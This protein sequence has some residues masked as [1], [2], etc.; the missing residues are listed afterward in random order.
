MAPYSLKFLRNILFFVGGKKVERLDDSLD[1][2][3]S[4]QEYVSDQLH[5][6]KITTFKRRHI[7]SQCFSLYVYIKMYY[8]TVRVR[9]HVV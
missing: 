7:L 1:M 2:N 3:E 6:N 8:G 4:Y 9:E 5:Y